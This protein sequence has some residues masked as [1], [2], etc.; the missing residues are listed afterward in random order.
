MRLSSSLA[1]PSSHLPHPFP[2]QVPIVIGG[3]ALPASLRFRQDMPKAGLANVTA[4]Y[5]NLLGFEAPEGYE[6][7][8]LE[9]AE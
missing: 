3:P 4:T 2:S 9:V 1:P 6:P 5:M 7:T 8:L